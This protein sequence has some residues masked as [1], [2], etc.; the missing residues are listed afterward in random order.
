M[1]FFVKPLCEASV[2]KRDAEL[3]QA[4]LQGGIARCRPGPGAAAA[5]GAGSGLLLDIGG[6]RPWAQAFALLLGRFVSRFARL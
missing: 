1:N 2:S 4:L 5:G 6:A 3:V